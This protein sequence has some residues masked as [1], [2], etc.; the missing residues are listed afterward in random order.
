MWPLLLKYVIPLSIVY[1]AQYLVN[2]GLAGFMVFNCAQGFGLSKES[3]YRCK[4]LNYLTPITII[5]YRVSSPLPIGSFHLT[6]IR[7][8]DSF[9]TCSI[10][11]VARL[12]SLQCVIL[13]RWCFLVICP[14]HQ[15]HLPVDSH[16]RICWW[17]F[18]CKQLL[19]NPQRSSTGIKRVFYEYHIDS[20]TNRYNIGRS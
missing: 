10:A 17:I 2:Q 13:F 4:W 1:Y 14:T 20:R 15:C 8:L 9:A 3:Q 5:F 19:S 16:A 7:K 11:Y 6:F 12:A 18:V